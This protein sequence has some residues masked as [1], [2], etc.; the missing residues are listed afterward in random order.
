MT[1]YFWAHRVFLKEKLVSCSFSKTGLSHCLGSC[2][3]EMWF[4][5]KAREAL[6]RGC[7]CSAAVARLQ[8]LVPAPHTVCSVQAGY[9]VAP[10]E[11][12]KECGQ[13]LIEKYLK[14]H[15]SKRVVFA[16]CSSRAVGKLTAI[17]THVLPQQTCWAGW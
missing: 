5:R 11:K 10:D 4:S 14:P 2:L 9:E 16:A 15:V 12:R 7:C 3:L 17:I 1:R 6:G 8:G 13:H